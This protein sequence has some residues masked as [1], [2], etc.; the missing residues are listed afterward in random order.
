MMTRTIRLD[1]VLRETVQTCYTDLVT[2][3]TGEAVRSSIVRV[4]YEHGPGTAYLDFSEVGLVDWSCADE[5]VAKLLLG[6][7]H[8]VCVV[9]QGLREEQIEAIEH[10]LEHHAIAALAEDPAGGPPR[11]LG[12]LAPELVAAFRSLYGH[13]SLT[14]E[15]LARAIGWTAA[16]AEAALERLAALRLVRRHG[17]A[18][19]A[20]TRPA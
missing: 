10:V 9:L 12:R 8:E 13:G 18:Y 14:A 4:L 15:E 19:A 6:P 11:V 5:V 16:Q 20:P 3:R 1:R 2:R 17:P 7:P